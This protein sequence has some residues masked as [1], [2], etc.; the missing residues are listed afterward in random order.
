MLPRLLVKLLPHGKCG[1][2]LLK[3]VGQSR[4]SGGGN[5]RLWKEETSFYTIAKL[6][7]ILNL[8][9]TLL[10]QV[11]TFIEILIFYLTINVCRKKLTDRAIY[12]WNYFWD[13]LRYKHLSLSCH[14]VFILDT[15]ITR[16]CCL[17]IVVDS[18]SNKRAQQMSFNCKCTWC[19]QF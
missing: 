12:T 18:I 2:R 1:C 14:L 10:L 9:L 7:Q 5:M 6:L 16:F 3:R 8:T 4:V 15:F 19:R 17:S 13:N 11:L